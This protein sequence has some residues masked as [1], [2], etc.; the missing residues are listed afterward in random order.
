MPGIREDRTKLQVLL[1]FKESLDQ[2]LASHKEKNQL[3]AQMKE[4][5]AQMK[6]VK[7]QMEEVEAQMEEVEAQMG[8]MTTKV[9]SLEAYRAKHEKRDLV[10]H[11]ANTLVLF[12]K[13]LAVRMNKKLSHTESKGNSD[14]HAVSMRL[15]DA[16]T[17]WKEDQWV[18]K[19]SLPIKYHTKLKSVSNVRYH[20]GL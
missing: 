2:L 4:V 8:S 1:P 9:N 3:S 11:E 10:L 17:L 6:E 13:A 14:E 12:I 18:E 19:T 16:H 5:M 15:S 20:P 7:A